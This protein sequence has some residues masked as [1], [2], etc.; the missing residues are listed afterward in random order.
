[1]NE[2][3]QQ[4]LT[5]GAMTALFLSACFV[6][7]ALTGQINMTLHEAASVVGGQTQSVHSGIHTSKPDTYTGAQ[8]ILIA[9]EQQEKGIV[10][11]ADGIQVTPKSAQELMK[12]S[13]FEAQ[14]RYTA[15]YIRD[16]NGQLTEIRF[17]RLP[18]VK[19][20]L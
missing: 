17:A 14:S 6:A 20:D 18:A 2:N 8:A 4:M 1:M 19:E 15:T 12:D 5:L 3:V 10:I 13:V 7:L 16:G 9:I 11:Q